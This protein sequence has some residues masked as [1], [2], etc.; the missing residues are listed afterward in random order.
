MNELAISSIYFQRSSADNWK[1][2]AEAGIRGAEGSI[3]PRQPVVSL[4]LD[5]CESI[6]KDM[7]GGGLAV[8]SLHL[9][10]NPGWDISTLDPSERAAAIRNFKPLLDWASGKGIGIA[11]LH[12]SGEPIGDDIREE[13]LNIAKQA[14]NELSDYA[15]GKCVRIT[16]ENLPRDCL[17]H[18]ADE[19][20][21]LTESGKNAGICFDVNHLLIET[22]KDFMRK[23]GK[24]IITTHLSDYDRIDERHWVI[25]DGCIDWKELSGL[26]SECGYNGRYLFEIYE[27]MSEAPFTLVEL[28]RRFYF[29]TG[30]RY[31]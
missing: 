16:L 1:L 8:S 30:E 17:G 14:I 3:G 9:P 22:H 15:K 12:A 10:F 26:F 25:G 23:A 7:T 28:V 18:T 11:V 19:M 2:A 24:Y 13:K 27:P 29:Y 20:L 31:A 6:Y 5:E 4:V 21:F